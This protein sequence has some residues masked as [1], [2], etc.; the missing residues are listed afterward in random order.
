MSV[1]APSLVAGARCKDRLCNST[2]VG[3]TGFSASPKDPFGEADQPPA[4]NQKPVW[5]VFV[6]VRGFSAEGGCASGAEP[7][8]QIDRF[9]SG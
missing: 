1:V 3:V 2:N 4:K 7:G 5:Q 9:S 8:I 6:G